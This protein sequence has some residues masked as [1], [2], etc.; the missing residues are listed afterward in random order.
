MAI[1]KK[2]Y[3]I[4]TKTRGKVSNTSAEQKIIEFFKNTSIHQMDDLEIKSNSSVHLI[5]G[6]SIPK[7]AKGDLFKLFW[8]KVIGQDFLNKSGYTNQFKAWFNALTDSEKSYLRMKFNSFFIFFSGSDI[9]LYIL[10]HFGGGGLNEDDYPKQLNEFFRDLF[11]SRTIK[12]IPIS[13]TKTGQNLSFIELIRGTNN[14][15]LPFLLNRLR[16]LIG[17][18]KE[19]YK[20]LEEVYLKKSVGEAFNLLRRKSIIPLQLKMISWQPDITAFKFKF[21]KIYLNG[22]PISKPLFLNSL[23]VN[24]NGGGPVNIV[25]LNPNSFYKN[26]SSKDKSICLIKNNKKVFDNVFKGVPTVFL[27]FFD[28]QNIKHSKSIK[29]WWDARYR[30]FDSCIWF[31]YASLSD[32]DQIDSVLNDIKYY[33]GKGIYQLDTSKEFLEFQVRLFNNSYIERIGRNGHHSGNVTPFSFHSELKMKIN[34]TNKLKEL[35][36]YSWNILIVDDHS[37]KSLTQDQNLNKVEIIKSILDGDTIYFDNNVHTI[38]LKSNDANVTLNLFFSNTPEEAKERIKDKSFYYDIVLLDYLFEENNSIEYGH[39]LIMDLAD[40]FD[41]MNWEKIWIMPI[42]VY[43]NA[44]TDSLRNALIPLYHKHLIISEG[45]DPICTPELFKYRFFSFLA[46]QKEELI[47]SPT[48]R[49]SFKDLLKDTE[50]NIKKKTVIEEWSAELFTAIVEL[51]VNFKRF[52]SMKEKG[53]AFAESALLNDFFDL[54]KEEDWYHIQNLFYLVAFGN[55]YQYPQI[56]MEQ[57]Y[58]YKTKLNQNP[59][60]ERL[61]KIITEKFQ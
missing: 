4:I 41:K 17:E 47:T 32:P 45:A 6:E 58:I 50:K 52:C 43:H 7:V 26:V 59:L 20:S 25:Y 16:T 54:A 10:I 60:F 48:K 1:E 55:K 13:N 11:P 3:L 37:V 18:Q 49:Q 38:K 5:I 46:L 56:R 27:G 40:L 2:A 21:P 12:F 29:L 31:R 51:G 34:A 57:L 22:I 14:L 44:L 28:L 9:A 39:N 35:N 33:Y 15:S 24:I 23:D 19:L 53:S 8:T 36:G 42:S 30:F 61:D